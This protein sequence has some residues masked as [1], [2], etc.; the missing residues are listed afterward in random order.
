MNILILVP[1]L[2]LIL[3]PANSDDGRPP[4]RPGVS[5]RYAREA[6]ERRREEGDEGKGE[7]KED[8]REQTR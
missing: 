8:R 3:I 2:I 1:I 6:G 5:R 4:S 7:R